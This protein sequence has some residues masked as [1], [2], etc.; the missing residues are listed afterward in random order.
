MPRL[1]TQFVSSLD[2]MYLW[3]FEKQKRDTGL[4]LGAVSLGV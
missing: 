4:G 2:A 1:E 3:Y